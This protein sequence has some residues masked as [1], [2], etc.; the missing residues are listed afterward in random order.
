MSI[1]VLIKQ[2]IDFDFVKFC[3]NAIF[4]S[5][6]GPVQQK[7]LNLKRLFIVYSLFFF[8]FLSEGSVNENNDSKN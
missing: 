5:S 8:I 1:I 2:T 6:D 4:L 3:D 7:S